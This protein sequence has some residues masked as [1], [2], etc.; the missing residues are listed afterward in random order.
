MKLKYISGFFLIILIICNICSCKSGVS[1]KEEGE[2]YSEEETQINKDTFFV[3]ADRLNLRSKPDLNGK[4]ITVLIKGDELI[5][6]E[7]S[8]DRVEI[9]GISDYWYRVKT[10]V[11]DEGWVFAGYLTKEKPYKHNLDSEGGKLPKY[12]TENIPDNL[13]ALEYYKEGKRLYD[14]GSYESAVGYLTRACEEDPAFGKAYFQL[15]LAYQ[16][17]EDNERAVDVY[18]KV[19]VLMPDS[20]WAHNNLGLALIR[21]GDYKRAVEVLEKA[22][23]LKPEG[24]ETESSIED[25]YDIARK[26]LKAA[27]NALNSQ[28]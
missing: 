1:E 3:K 14:K 9:D 22:L 18:E 7:K 10:E 12:D 21:T 5:L 6:L 27:Q 26:N 24:R 20:F 19:I 13:S 8:S 15:G 11:G 16:D 23:T 4:V 25:A 28:Y 17:L 2:V